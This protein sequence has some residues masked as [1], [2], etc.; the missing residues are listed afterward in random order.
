VCL[1]LQAT[2]IGL[3]SNIEVCFRRHYAPLL[4]LTRP[5]QLPFLVVFGWCN[6]DFLK[7]WSF[8]ITLAN[9]V[10]QW[11]SSRSF[12]RCMQPFMISL[13]LIWL[14][15][16]KGCHFTNKMILLLIGKIITGF[17]WQARLMLSSSLQITESHSF[18]RAPWQV[19]GYPYMVHGL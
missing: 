16:K 7:F 3:S 13:T 9:S 11:F 6:T 17:A 18:L 2:Q 10:V 14:W 1:C 5:W 8:Q 15:P 12:A 4:V 19:M